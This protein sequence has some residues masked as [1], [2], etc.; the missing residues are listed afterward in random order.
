ML[1]FPRRALAYLLVLALLFAAGCGSDS[2]NNGQKAADASSQVDAGSDT[3]TASD[4]G[5]GDSGPSDSGPA[6]DSGP[7]ADAGTDTQADTSAGHSVQESEPNDGAAAT[8]FDEINV[9][10]FVSGTITQGDSDIFHVQ[11]T[12]GKVYRAT[13]ILPQNG[14]PLQPHLTVFDDGRGSNGPAN[15]YVKIV[16]GDQQPLEFLAM[17]EGGYYVAVRD[18]RNVDDSSAN[19]GGAD[20]AYRLHVDEVPIADVTAGTLS[21]PATQHGTL[22]SAGAID[23]YQFDATE[24]TNVTVDLTA[25]G[26]MDGRLMVFAPSTGSWI[27]RNDNRTASDVNPLLDAPM[28]AG[29]GLLLVVE[30]ITEQTTSLDYQFDASAK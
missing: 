2:S 15:D 18:G 22:S 5:P 25:A 19:V 29:G 3:S 16:R 20:F 27:A 17:G 1:D 14:S 6:T 13:V 23:L 8:D 30:N 11:T 7:S 24:G 21:F 9:G 12:P 26:D 10:D 4:A 28:S